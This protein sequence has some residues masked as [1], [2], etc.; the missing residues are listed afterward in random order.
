MRQQLGAIL[1]VAGLALTTA[2]SS[3]AAAATTTRDTVT[4]TSPSGAQRVTVEVGNSMS[5]TPATINVRAGQPVELTLRN[6][7]FILHDF[8]LAEGVAQPIKVEAGG[9]ATASA[10][11][12]IDRPGSYTFICAAPG[13]EGAG[14]KGTITAQ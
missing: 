5:F 11:F 8:S 1:L 3:G 12:T 14:M 2:C 13:H 7:G 6:G 10:T 9:G 4:S